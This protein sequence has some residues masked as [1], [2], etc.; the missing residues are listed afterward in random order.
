MK[1]RMK[2]P[3]GHGG[4]SH[5]G[6]SYTPDAD[7]IIEVPQEAVEDAFSHGFTLVG[8]SAA[9]TDQ[10]QAEGQAP[11]D[12]AGVDLTKLNKKGLLQFA[13]EKLGLDLD[14]KKTN[15]ELVSEVE[16]ALANNTPAEGQAAG[17][18]AGA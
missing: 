12:G 15:K 3:H 13:K 7:G 4:L 14:A 8:E 11:G 5:K 17:D 9:K 16:A 6:V 10:P 18:G 2:G 1:A